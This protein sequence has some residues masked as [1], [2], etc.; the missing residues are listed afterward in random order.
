M[1][2]ANNNNTNNLKLMLAKKAKKL[3]SCISCFL[4]LLLS[5]FQYKIFLFDEKRNENA[6][7]LSLGY[8]VYSG[9][10]LWK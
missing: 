1:K 8:K 5:S 4:L 10:M 6:N 7:D 2:N 9:V 3:Y